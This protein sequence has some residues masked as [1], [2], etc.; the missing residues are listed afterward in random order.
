MGEDTKVTV[1]GQQVNGVK[2]AIP[3]SYLTSDD[4]EVKVPK[5]FYR[6]T[7][8][9]ICCAITTAVVLI[10]LIVILVLSFTVFKAKDPVIKVTGITLKSFS[11]TT[12]ST[13]TNFK[14]DVSLHLNVSVHNPNIASFKYTNSSTF[15]Y[16]RGREVGSAPIPAGKVGAEKTEKLETN[17]DIQA[18]PIVM[19]A[20][21]TSDLQ[22]GIIPINTHSA[23]RGKLDII[24]IFKHHAISTSDCTANILV[25]NQTLGD[26]NCN[27]HIKL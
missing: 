6:R 19:N 2:V 25:A 10:I 17:L 23:I 12:D 20:N 21:L 15:L 11:F 4:A 1:A 24:N 9:Q 3:P 5:G 18:L 8:C 7:S 27:Y 14:L 22:A 16:Y 13:L 26:Y